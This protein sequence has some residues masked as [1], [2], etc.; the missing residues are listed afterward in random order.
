MCYKCTEDLNL[1]LFAL[2]VR[3][4][5]PLA[6]LLEIKLFSWSLVSLF[7][8]PL[9]TFFN[10]S[11]AFTCVY[12]PFWRAHVHNHVLENRF[13]FDIFPLS[14]LFTLIRAFFQRLANS[15]LCYFFLVSNTRRSWRKC[16]CWNLWNTKT[17]S[18]KLSQ[19]F[20]F[21]TSIFSETNSNLKKHSHSWTVWKA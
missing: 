2:S 7:E 17:S 4:R 3:R 14:S 8:P 11:G 5:L 10:I 1:C 12:L 18:S 9:Q 15:G 6:A 16:H 13:R 19:T 20:F 21:A